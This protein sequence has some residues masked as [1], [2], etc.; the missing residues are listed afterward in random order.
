[1]VLV[2][3]SRHLRMSDVLF[4]LLWPLSWVLANGYGTMRK[5]NKVGLQRELEK[6]ALPSYTIPGHSA[7]IIDGMC[8]VPKM[9]GNGQTFSHLADSALTDI[10]HEGVR[11]HIIVVGFD[12]YRREDST[13]NAEI[14]NR[15]STTGIQFRNTAPYHRSQQWRSFSAARPIRPTS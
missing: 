15:G 10:L 12:V 3:E 2:A 11:S 4:H 9:K 8:P 7:T 5:T 14:S 1:M 13:K 6:Q